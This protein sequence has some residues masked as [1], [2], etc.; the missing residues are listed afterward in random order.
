ME[1]GICLYADN[2]IV[3]IEVYEIAFLVLMIGMSGLKVSWEKS[4]VF[5]IG[6]PLKSLSLPPNISLSTT[7]F[8]YLGIVMHNNLTNHLILC[9]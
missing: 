4:T 6:P 9:H 1:K 3:C 8:K 5:P 2:A 7:K